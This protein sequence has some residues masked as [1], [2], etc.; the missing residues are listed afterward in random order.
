MNSS[1]EPN[2]ANLG[3]LLNDFAEEA[4]SSLRGLP[5]LLNRFYREPAD[6]EPINAVFRAV[7]S[8][9]GNASFFGL[10]AI[11]TFAHVLE[12]TLDRIRNRQ[13]TLTAELEREL[14][15]SFD[16]LDEMVGA[17][18]QGAI[19]TEQPTRCQE[20]LDRIAILAESAPAEQ[21]SHPWAVLLKALE[22]LDIP[23]MP[24]PADWLAEAARN[25]IAELDARVVELEA[26][27]A[28][29]APAATDPAAV[30]PATL[31]GANWISANIDLAERISA[32]L[33][34][35]LAF[36]RDQ[37]QP[38]LGAE[39]V[40]GS[41]DLASWA[42]GEDRHELAAALTSAA[43]NFEAVAGSPIGLDRQLLG[44]IWDGI[45]PELVK[46][47]DPDR[48][49]ASV[50]AAGQPSSAT[51]R[52][53]APETPAGRAA[54]ATGGRLV[55]VK[56]ER[57]DEFLNRV[58]RLFITGEMLKDLQSRMLET[59]QLRPLVEEL[60][61]ITRSFSEQANALQKGL[62]ALRRVA[63]AGL[64]SKFPRMARTLAE[65]L[66][67]QVEVCLVG[68]D[69]ELDKAL[70][71]DL[72][73]PLTH[74]LRNAVDHGI[75][76]PAARQARGVDESGSVTLSAEV[77][78]T[79]ARITIRDDGR[80]IDPQR[81][82]D[83]AVEK[84]LFSPAQVA[85]MSDEQAV[86][87][88]FHPGFSTAEKLSDI[89]GR[90]VGLDVVRTSIRKHNG[91]VFVT[92]QVGVGT[93][94]RLEVPLREA[95]IVVDGLTVRQCGQDFVVPFEFIREITQLK[96]R[97]VAAIQGSPVCTI[98][99]S[100]Y[101]ARE[102]AAI[103]DLPTSQAGDDKPVSA[104][105]VG[106]PQGQFCL[107]VDEVRGNRKVVVNSINNILP[108]ANKIAGVAQLG[109]GRLALVVSIPDVVKSL[110]NG[111]GARVGHE[112]PLR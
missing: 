98:R 9:K 74:I 47:V 27:Q 57:L 81:L 14:V 8:V 109:G 52:T 41:R 70:I 16:Q 3:E 85:A 48:S 19:D 89:S 67:K 37:Y 108:Q 73:A 80:G 12:N 92:S 15:A 5:S 26:L 97:D 95:V 77:T 7:H 99:G 25:H 45:W 82:R 68:E 50:A 106:T 76:L 40:A 110:V 20:L 105:L 111:R 90:G 53:A 96:T 49:P 4:V 24:T 87:L 46:L 44:L 38:E 34:L 33:D 58:A 60:R 2:T 91:E 75:D 32:V 93:T 54:D 61:Q 21:P 107:L 69:V 103:L 1:M 36:D 17:A 31:A 88:I 63:V 35:F 94:F 10:T 28:S 64:F 104:V 62:F 102:L 29:P 66:G 55:R 6:A 11:K 30:T 51:E 18:A 83:K 101:D 23:G 56:E 39:F 22:M 72:D 86:D 78:R 13:L 84:G 100:V 59:G 112:L 79:H 71:E 65:Q 43:E 42:Q